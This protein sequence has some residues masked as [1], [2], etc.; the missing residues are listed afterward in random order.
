VGEADERKAAARR[1]FDRRARSYETG[2]TSRWRDPV[3]LA[4]LAALELTAEDRVLD[5]ACGTG[6]GSRLAAKTA[7]SVV[8]V[9]LS[10]EMLARATVAAAGV[11]NLR[12][13]L[14]DAERLPFDDGGF[15]ALM[16]SNAFHHYP[17]PSRAVREMVR[18]VAPRGRVVIGDA[19][20]DRWPARIADVFLRR[21]EPGHV[22]LYRS[23][24]LGA[25][26]R[27]AG[28]T[29]V[30]LRRLA[31]GG[32]AIVRGVVPPPAG[33]REEHRASESATIQPDS[34]EDHKHS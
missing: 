24:E 6:R 27:D 14:A 26:F 33:V 2:A 9:D 22:R 12:F 4:S 3:Q 32:F 34:S 5:L 16:C 8:G 11:G 13:E 21:F 29:N 18:V 7:A 15:T 30:M 19:C 10:P 1:W 23:A 20:S 31:A 25:Y 17:N 28:L